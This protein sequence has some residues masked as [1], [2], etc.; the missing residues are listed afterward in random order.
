MKKV[1]I[2]VIVLLALLGTFSAIVRATV[3][4]GMLRGA[5]ANE[6]SDRDRASLR[7]LAG[8]I[9]VDDSS[10]QYRE[11]EDDT[12]AGAARFNA[13]PVR[14]ALSCHPGRGLPVAGTAAIDS[15]AAIAAPRYPP[16]AGLRVAGMRHPIWRHRFVPSRSAS[17]PLVFS[18]PR[19]RR[20]V[21]G[22]FSTAVR[23]RMRP[24]VAE[25]SRTTAPGCCAR[26]PWRTRLPSSVR[27][28]FSCSPSSRCGWLCSEGRRFGLASSSPLLPR[29]G[30]SGAARNHRR[31]P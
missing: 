1:V 10:Q 7:F 28:V 24:F 17:R 13:L 4:I 30:G 14:D 29:N 12:R 19:H 26:W 25:T 21:A 18:V 2:I 23:A 11:L 8:M 6:L 5:P 31:G 20:W 27:S 16:A 9:G 15:Q 3:V 22:G